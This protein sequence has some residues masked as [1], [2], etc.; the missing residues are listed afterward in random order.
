MLAQ[1]AK[2]EP[3]RILIDNFYEDVNVF[4]DKGEVSFS[5]I[6]N[7]TYPKFLG[8]DIKEVTESG[9]DVTLHFETMFPAELSKPIAA[10]PEYD[11][12][13]DIEKHRKQRFIYDW[14]AIRNEIQSSIDDLAQR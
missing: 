9:K 2:G 11:R 13:V 4:H 1:S 12:V 7:L 5:Y 10:E 6:G 3:R 8:F 14:T